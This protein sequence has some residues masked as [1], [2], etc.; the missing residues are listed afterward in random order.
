MLAGWTWPQLIVA[1]MLGLQIVGGICYNGRTRK[2]VDAVDFILQSGI[3]ALV[4][5]WGGFWK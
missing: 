2:P 3:W 5:G 4:L 1:F